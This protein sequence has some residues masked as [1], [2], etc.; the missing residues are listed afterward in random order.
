MMSAPSEMRC[1]SMPI[2]DMTK[3]VA[4]STSGIVK[5][6][7]MPARQPSASS[8]TISTIATA[9]PNASRNWRIDWLTTCAWSDTRESSTP[10][11]RPCSMRLSVRSTY[12]GDIGAGHHGGAEQHRL[13]ALV[14]R[15]R[16]RRI[17][18]AALDVGDI[19]EAEGLPAG[20]QPQFTDVLDRAQS[21]LDVDAHGSFAGFDPAGGVHRVLSGKRRLDV[22]HREPAFGQH[23]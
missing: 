6:T 10:I 5:A 17:L 22:E 19:A 14:A 1:R 21:A 4:A 18:K 8:D 15:L 12:L 9:S 7:T 3:N 16:R 11:G 13:P 2:S 20:T 23:C